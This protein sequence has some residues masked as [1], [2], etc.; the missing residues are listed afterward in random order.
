M[1]QHEILLFDPSLH[2][3]PYFVYASIKGSGKSARL[4]NNVISTKIPCA[5]LNIELL[6]AK[7]VCASRV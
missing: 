1:A 4:L 3:R 2:L 7:G 6:V 5:D